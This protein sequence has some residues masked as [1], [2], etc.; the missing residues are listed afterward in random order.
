MT[1]RRRHRITAVTTA[2]A[3]VALT[4]TLA[5]GCEFDDSLDCLSSAD[6]IADSVAAI[7]RAGADAIEDPT[8]TQ[9]SID[10]IEK[11]LDKIND[12][13]DDNKVGDA[14]DDLN[15]AV[16]NYNK[17]ILN[18]DTDPDSSKIDAAADQ[19]KDLCTS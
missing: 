17:A 15:K 2:A 10:T 18:G 3:A 4:A 16:A 12:K 7:H 9:K 8:R 14:V 5:A 19:L 6:T 13:T 1:A 11:N